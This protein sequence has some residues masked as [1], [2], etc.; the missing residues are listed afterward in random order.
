MEPVSV[1]FGIA[2]AVS[3][4]LAMLSRDASARSVA[5]YLAVV[6]A[7]ANA[8]WRADMLWLLPM[9]DLGL[10]VAA[11]AIWWAGRARWAALIVNAV[12]I[13]LVLHVLDA[14]TAHVFLI[15]Y[16][17]ALNA[18]F[19]WMLVVVADAGGGHVRDTLFRRLRRI[20]GALSYSP[21]GLRNG[22]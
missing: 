18:T 5:G 2:C 16:L 21:G 8:A 15:A 20:R 4:W 17:H 1:L 9:F 19:V 3:W 14:I 11:L 13:R 6:W 10:G 12:V 22:R 7:L